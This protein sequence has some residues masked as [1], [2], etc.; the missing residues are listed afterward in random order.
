MA[1]DKNA[2]EEERALKALQLASKY[3]SSLISLAGEKT[4][5]KNT[6]NR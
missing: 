6:D 1:V 5:T 2:R 4:D 3:L